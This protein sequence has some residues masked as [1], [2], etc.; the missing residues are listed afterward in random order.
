M[1]KNKIQN[2]NLKLKIL[3]FILC[4]Y[5][6]TF[7]FLLLSF[8]DEQFVYDAQ[9]KRNPFIPL[10]T[11]DG[12]LLKL[13]REEQKGDLLLEGIIYDEQGMSY[14]IVNSKVVKIGDIVD[15]YQIL[16]IEKNKVIFLKDG[17]PLEVDLKKEER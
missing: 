2:H 3:S 8:A 1:S 12:K 6:F 4:F 17:Q 5:F 7:T 11:S 9:G 16:K 13:E 10:V 14:A 15:D